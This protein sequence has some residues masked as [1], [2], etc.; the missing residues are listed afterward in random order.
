MVLRKGDHKLVETIEMEDHQYLTYMPTILCGWSVAG[1]VATLKHW[2][3]AVIHGTT[4]E[5]THVCMETS[6]RIQH[7]EGKD[8]GACK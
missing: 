3:L 6:Y 4:C 2:I 7:E 8:P 5:S 1:L